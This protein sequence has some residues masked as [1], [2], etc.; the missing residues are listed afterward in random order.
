MEVETCDI[1][2]YKKGTRWS[3]IDIQWMS[4]QTPNAWQMCWCPQ[5]PN[6]WDFPPQHMQLTPRTYIHAGEHTNVWGCWTPTEVSKHI[7]VSNQ[8]ALTSLNHMQIPS[9]TCRCTGSIWDMWGCLNIWGHWEHL[10][11]W[12]YLNI[13]GASRCAPSVKHTCQ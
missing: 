3:I 7:W 9:R 6:I 4:S 8:E 10:N 11:I 1:M 13:Q 12:G 5:T 2:N